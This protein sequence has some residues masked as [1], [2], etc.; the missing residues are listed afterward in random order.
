MRGIQ[1]ARWERPFPCPSPSYIR[2]KRAPASPLASE[3]LGSSLA[4][5]PQMPRLRPN[6]LQTTTSRTA[7]HNTQ[8]KIHLPQTGCGVT[9]KGGTGMGW[10]ST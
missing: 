7:E 2:R 6:R 9:E 10:H 3:W 1:P 8:P 4:D 5:S